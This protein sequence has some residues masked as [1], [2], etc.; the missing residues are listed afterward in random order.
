[1]IVVKN[2]GAR[3][4]TAGMVSLAA[5]IAASMAPM[6]AGAQQTQS[7][8]AEFI[9]LEEIVVT[10]RR[11]EEKLQDV[12]LAITSFSSTSLEA[13]GV[14]NLRDLSYL[15]PG[16]TVNSGGSEFA[17]QPVIR[18]LTN[19]NGGAG[20][21]N[22][23]VF[24]DGVYLP[25]T[26]AISLALID[27]ARI[28][29][30]KG[31]VSALYGRNS[32][33]GAINYV[34]KKPSLRDYEGKIS[35]TY[36]NDG[37]RNLSGAIGGPLIKDVLGVR[38]AAGYDNFDGSYKDEVNGRR[39][40]GWEKKDAQLSFTLNASENLEVNGAVYYGDDVFAQSAL[41]YNVGNCGP[42]STNPL[43]L[44]EYTQYCGR[45]DPDAHPVEVPAIPT[46]AG[47]SGNNREVLNANLRVDYNMDWGSVAWLTGYNDIKQQ[48]LNDFIGMRDGILF[49]LVPGPGQ[50]RLLETFGNDSLNKDFSQELR[51][52]SN[53]DQSFRWAFGGF[54]YTADADTST[55]VGLDG[56]RI[57]AGQTINTSAIYVTTDG[58]FAPGTV[59]FSRGDDRQYSGFIGLEYDI[60]EGLTASGEYRYTDQKRGVLIEPSAN[61]L[62]VGVNNGAYPPDATF[63]F[64]NYRGTLKYQVTPEIM[65]YASVANGTKAGGFN[66][67]A[68]VAADLTF[69]PE[70]NTTYEAGVKTSFFDNRLQANAAVFHIDSTNLQ[71]SGP[72]SNASS[73]GLVTKNFGST[74]SD[75]FEIELAAKPAQGVRFNAGVGYSNPKFNGDAYDFSSVAS[76]RAI[77]TCATKVVTVSTPQGSRQAVSLKG[78]QVS[79]TS[80]LQ[81]T[82]GTELTGEL[83]GDWNWFSRT[84]FRYESK[85]YSLP[86]NYNWFGPR[87]VVNHR[88][89][90]ENGNL[91]FTAYIDN[92]T[93]DMTP[94]TA[95]YNT[96][97]NDFNANYTMYLPTGRTYGLTVSYTY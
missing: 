95:S 40:G 61:S 60:I 19:L 65:T 36:G 17:V 32:F 34:S 77:P 22:V 47:V 87:T 6:Q 1:M 21:P 24:L 52:A 56:S 70:E 93:N 54:Y 66:A 89:G 11:L 53:R 83:V 26:S 35:A 37:Q 33:G 64:S 68:T 81:L 50:V 39:S 42:R 88:M 28:E 29:V 10:A 3:C 2:A 91:K 62:A 58:R 86:N 8:S 18:G 4:R 72:S 41:A 76:C 73:T 49:N 63:T 57:P 97:L 44:N 46:G 85:Q 20:D 25:N 69:D 94:E 51:I 75:G 7:S 84:D 31:P 12:P 92:L 48:R 27:V 90:I 78:N 74:D 80:K 71:I 16:I 30:V 67:R 23:A 9:G 55:L 45:L 82:F 38:L 79:R 13:A 59:Q 5:M 43:T 96:R 14:E 15:T